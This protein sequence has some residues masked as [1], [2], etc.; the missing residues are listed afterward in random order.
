VTHRIKIG[1]VMNSSSTVSAEVGLRLVTTPQTF[2][3]LTGSLFYSRQDPYAVR[4]AFHVGLEEPVEWIFA[5]DLLSRG[6]QGRQGIGDVQ[7]RPSTGPAGGEPG[8]VLNVHRDAI[9]T[10]YALGVR[11]AP[12]GS[13]YLGANAHSL[14]MTELATA[15]SRSRGEAA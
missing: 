12:A 14:A 11:T 2:V 1:L 3:P 8:S 5:R 6:I 15:A 7:V 4:I 10:L 9:A 13:Y